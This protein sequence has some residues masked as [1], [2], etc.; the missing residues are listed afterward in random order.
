MHVR[1]SIALIG[2][3]S[4]GLPLGMGCGFTISAGTIVSPDKPVRWILVER[5]GE[6]IGNEFEGP[7][8][9]DSESTFLTFEPV[10][11]EPPQPEELSVCAQPIN[12]QPMGV[13]LIS[14][15]PRH[16]ARPGQIVTAVVR[17][18][19]ANPNSIYRLTVQPSREGVSILGNASQTVRGQDA[20]TFRF[21]RTSTGQ[22]GLVIQA[23]LE[24][25]DFF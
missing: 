23:E 2:L 16:S 5:S 24:S 12:T 14:L 20:A 13:E 18:A 1:V 19:D 8:R 22:G 6:E 9:L 17:V 7:G 3:L 11:E 10:Y 21:T 25:K 15:T 4:F